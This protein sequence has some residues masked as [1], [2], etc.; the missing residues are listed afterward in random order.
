MVLKHYRDI[1][2]TGPKITTC[3]WLYSFKF[4]YSSSISWI[5]KTQTHTPTEWFIIG[6]STRT[7]GV[8]TS[9]TDGKE[10][11]GFDSF[12]MSQDNCCYLCVCCV[13]LF[14]LNMLLLLIWAVLWRFH[15]ICS[16]SAWLQMKITIT[17]ANL[18]SDLSLGL[19]QPRNDAKLKQS[20]QQKWRRWHQKIDCHQREAFNVNFE[21]CHYHH[22]K[23][24]YLFF[25]TKGQSDFNLQAGKHILMPSVNITGPKQSR[26][27][28]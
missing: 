16:L 18:H 26:L 23:P 9:G 15:Q 28:M 11:N 6:L 7:S 14:L 25:Q 22:S 4:T 12:A 5:R 8:N 1:T 17:C 21:W 3:F 24:Q 13:G 2:K 27:R 19:F 10:A 20:K